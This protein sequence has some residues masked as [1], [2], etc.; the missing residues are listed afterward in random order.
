[1]FRVRLF[2]YVSGVE[3]AFVVP[4]VKHAFLCWEFLRQTGR[5]S[6]PFVV[7]HGG[8][9][10]TPWWEALT[11]EGTFP[12][13]SQKEERW[14]GLRAW[15]SALGGS[16]ARAELWRKSSAGWKHTGFGGCL[17]VDPCL[18]PAAAGSGCKSIADWQNRHPNVRGGKRN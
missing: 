9:T 5:Q 6:C 15:K 12:P 18:S 13:L 4:S 14:C 8:E 16:Q 1:M 7:W 17:A 2:S 11:L 3:C 10:R